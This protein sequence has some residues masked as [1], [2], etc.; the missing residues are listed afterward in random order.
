MDCTVTYFLT[1]SKYTV[2]IRVNLRMEVFMTPSP[3]PKVPRFPFSPIV[4]LFLVPVD[5][6]LHAFL[7]EV[8]ALIQSAPSLVDA[9]QKDLDAH[10]LRK[11]AVREADK[12]WIANQTPNLPGLPEPDQEPDKPLMLGQ[13][14]PRTSGYVVLVALLL[15]GYWGAGFKSAD[16][17]SNMVESITLRVFFSNLGI[18]MPGRSTLTEL[19]NAVSVQT[20]LLV[21]DAQVARALLLNLDDF[22][23]FLQDSTHVDGHTAWPTDSKLMV[24]IVAR[25]IRIGEGLERF[26]LSPIECGAIRKYL[27]KMIKLNREIE[28]SHGKNGGKRTRRRRYEKMLRMAKQI[29]TLLTPKVVDLAQEAE[30]LDVRPSEKAIAKRA[31]ERLRADL[32][33]LEKV[34]T[35]CEARVLQ[36]K[37]VPMS[38]K[39][40][41]LSDPDAG[42]ISKGQR[43]PVIGYKPQVARSGAGFVTGL[44]LPQGNASD[45]KNLLPMVDEVIARTKVTPKVV[46]VD[47][48]Y[49]SAKNK[50]ALEDRNI[51]VISIN[52]AKGR[53]LTSPA[54]WDS[55]VFGEARDKR[56]AVES[57]MYT[58]KHGFDFGEVARRGLLAVHAELLEKALA[59][60]VCVTVRLRREAAHAAVNAPRQATA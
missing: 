6:E 45:S 22:K 44:H 57:L 24:D 21:L 59:Y 55:D 52:G 31:V 20:R 53:A 41:S 5:S 60:N 32:D 19:V 46:S 27:Q 8:H 40:L 1:N 30:S 33:A 47:D 10:G 56:S 23:T 2:I 49:A 54:D 3:R 18:K 35:A 11:K 39:V 51:E 7:E 12:E 37:K 14:R 26:N 25:L 29:H 58:L 9:V 15:R 17:T 36:E 34:Y 16:V 43:E 38:E 42:F 48:G 28:F 50:K 4:P 13:G